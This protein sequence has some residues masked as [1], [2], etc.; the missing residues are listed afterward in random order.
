MQC[1]VRGEKTRAQE[2]TYLRGTDDING[3]AAG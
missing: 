3:T 2:V 1:A